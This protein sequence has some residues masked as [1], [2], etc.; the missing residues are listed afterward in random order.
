MLLHE[1]WACTLHEKIW[2][3][4]NENKFKISVPMWNE[5]FDWHPSIRKNVNEIEDRI[6]F[7][8]RWYY[9][10]LLTPET[11]KL[12]ANSGSKIKKYEN[13]ENVP[14]LGI[15]EVVLVHCKIQ[16]PCIHLF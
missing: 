9:C 3:H 4:S 8:I 2:K 15:T 13:V 7:I 16:D 6:R 1:S 12:L 14:H 5:N 10:E 11:T